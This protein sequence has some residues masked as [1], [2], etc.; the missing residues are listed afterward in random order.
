MRWVSLS[1]AAMLLAAC[2]V[3]QDVQIESRNI[4][5]NETAQPASFNPNRAAL[6]SV[7]RQSGPT[8]VT[9]VVSK[10][11]DQGSNAMR[12]ADRGVAVTSGSGFVVEPSGYV[13]TAA[14][15][16]VAK[17]NKVS[18]RAANGRIYSGTVI[19]VIPNKDMALIKLQNFRG[20]PALPS[21]N[22]CVPR[23]T[24]VFSLGKPH[25]QGDTARVGEV[26]AMHFG[27]PVQY[28]QFGYPDAM[29]LRMNT[30]KGE[31]GGPLFNE[32]G[33][34]VGMV[35]STLA[36]ADGTPLNLAHA[37]PATSLAGFL[38]TH[39]SCSGNWSTLARESTEGC[40]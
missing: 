7:V 17:G 12:D 5:L 24:V 10:Q 23:G 15:V 19:D 38:C 11:N 34:L 25:S 28:G 16:A 36:A 6:D 2:S 20:K 40:S 21:G 18:A 33:Q 29:V 35:V 22:A 1:L 39:V 3:D 14:H 32:Q 26:E 30:Q 37:V 13:L 8:Y 9:L 27:R 4:E 31:S